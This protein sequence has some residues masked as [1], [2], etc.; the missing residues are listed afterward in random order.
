MDG[1]AEKPTEPIE[2]LCFR[3]RPQLALRVE[4]VNVGRPEL[5]EH[6]VA[7]G[8]GE[9]NELLRERLV[10]AIGGMRDRRLAIRKVQADGILDSDARRFWRWRNGDDRLGR[11]PGP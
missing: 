4:H 5:I 11:L 8:I 7:E 10:L 9:G 6:D 1:K 2:H 3:S